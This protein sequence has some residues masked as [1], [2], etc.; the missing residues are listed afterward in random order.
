MPVTEYDLNELLLSEKNEEVRKV[1]VDKEDE[2]ARKTMEKNFGYVYPYL[3]DTTLPLKSS[4]TTVLS[5]TSEEDKEPVYKMFEDTEEI[6]DKER[7]TTAH[8]F[9]ELYDFD[10]RPDVYS[11]GEEMIKCG[12]IEREKLQKIDLEKIG[13]C[14]NGGAFDS[15]KGKTLYREKGFMASLPAKDIFGGDSE[16]NVVIQGVIDLLAIGGK[17]AVIIDYKYSSKTA[18]ALKKTYAPQLR[19]YALAVEKILGVKVT[20]KYLLSLVTGEKIVID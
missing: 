9:M 10:G 18:E 6:T 5:S 12:L 8:N 15:L 7:G 20:E 13:L 2:E 19:L 17:T 3:S 4:V 14:I 16:K 1:L 11:A